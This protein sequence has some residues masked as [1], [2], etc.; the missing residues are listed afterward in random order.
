MLEI[1][2]RPLTSFWTVLAS[3]VTL[4]YCALAVQKHVRIHGQSP[5]A[6]R[7]IKVNSCLYSV[8]SLCFCLAIILSSDPAPESLKLWDDG[9]ADEVQRQ[10]YHF[11]KFYEYLDIILVLAS[12]GS[13]GLHF[14]FHHLTVS[15]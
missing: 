5:L 4:V 1:L 8:A 11:S 7:I 12:G 9:R 10:L 6:S 3:T 13:V 2:F 14:A 15:H